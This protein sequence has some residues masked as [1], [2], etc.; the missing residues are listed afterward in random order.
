[1]G[2]KENAYL[3][4]WAGGRRFSTAAKPG[5]GKTKAQDKS[6]S[7]IVDLAKNKI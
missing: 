3:A 4:R 7:A 6:P 5:G 2:E 1:M